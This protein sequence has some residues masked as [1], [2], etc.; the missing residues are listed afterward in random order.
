VIGLYVPL[1][2]LVLGTTVGGA[3]FASAIGLVRAILTPL[4]WATRCFL[5]VTGLALLIPLM[6][7]RLDAHMP[8][9]HA[10]VPVLWQHTMSLPLLGAAWGGVLGV[11]V[12]TYLVLPG[13]FYGLIMVSLVQSSGWASAVIWLLY[14]FTRGATIVGVSV[15]RGP[16]NSP[17]QAEPRLVAVASTMRLPLFLVLSTALMLSLVKPS[18]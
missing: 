8:E 12:L 14:G 6:S 15:A 5:V 7:P 11:G 4:D 10:Q 9:R 3:I 2:M 1:V 13:A 18:L 16:L 17:N